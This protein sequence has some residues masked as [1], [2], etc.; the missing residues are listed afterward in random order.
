MPQRATTD[1]HAYPV[2]ILGCLVASLALLLAL[3]R[4]WPA[5]PPPQPRFQQPAAQEV[6]AFEEV[7]PTAQQA[8]V[9]APPPPAPLPPV[10]VPDDVEIEVEELALA[11][12]ALPS[13]VPGVDLAAQA[14]TP[15]AQ[16]PATAAPARV[17]EVGPRL[18]RFVEPEYTQEAR[19]RRLRA[20]VVVEVHIDEKGQVVAVKVLD[21]YLLGKDSQR[22]ERVAALGYGLEES[23]QAAAQRTLFRPARRGTQAIRS[24]TTLTFSF[25]V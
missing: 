1:R 6:I 2:R 20:E 23:A 3:V 5:S 16:G 9:L 13:P 21:R 17:E 7:R 10:V 24:T 8:T 18:V 12:P 19:R 11:E 25:G 4:L 15:A 14:G 22:E